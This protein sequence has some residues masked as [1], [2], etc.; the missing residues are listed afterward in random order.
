[1]IR[2]STSAGLVAAS[3]GI[4]ALTAPARADLPRQPVLTADLATT[5]MDTCMSLAKDKGW[6]MSIVVLDAG[7]HMKTFLRMDGAGLGT[8]NIARR[9]ASTSV[10]S[11]QASGAVGARA[12][13]AKTGVPNAVAFA[14]DYIL[15]PGGLPIIAEDG[16]LLG[17][18]GASGSSPTNDTACAQ[19]GVDA[20]K[21][22]LK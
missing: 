21:G 16:T 7:N 6:H 20:I 9:K 1:M 18:I 3:L 10:L 11:G 14:P 22:Q 13:N 12:F 17:A 2:I 4:L 19:A 15:F 8:I 5:A